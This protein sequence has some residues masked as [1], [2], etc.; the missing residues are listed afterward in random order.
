MEREEALM[1]ANENT[2]ILHVMPNMVL[3]IG[4]ITLMQS[5]Q[6]SVNMGIL[7]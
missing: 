1:N 3:K 5:I 7:I 4:I 2:E 6:F